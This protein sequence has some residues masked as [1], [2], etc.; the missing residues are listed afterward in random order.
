MKN[1]IAI[2]LYVLLFVTTLPFLD[3]EQD[4]EITHWF[5]QRDQKIQEWKRIQKLFSFQEAIVLFQ[6]SSLNSHQDLLEQTDLIKEICDQDFV[7]SCFSLLQAYQLNSGE[8]DLREIL[9]EDFLEIQSEIYK[10]PFYQ[11]LLLSQGQGH[12]LYLRLKDHLE[13]QEKLATF[14]HLLSFEKRGFSLASSV[15][16]NLAINERSELEGRLFFALFPL[17]FILFFYYF[18][19]SISLIFCLLLSVITSISI[20]LSIMSLCGV[21]QSILSLIIAPI[22]LILTL[23]SATHLLFQVERHLKSKGWKEAIELAKRDLFRTL[24][25]NKITSIAG[26]LTLMLSIILPVKATGLFSALG[27]VISFY[28]LMVFF[29]FLLLK[30]Q[31]K[32]LLLDGLTQ[33]LD[34]FNQW[35]NNFIRKNSHWI[36]RLT[37]LLCLICFYL[38]FHLT[39]QSKALYL[40]PQ[41][42]KI[43]RMHQTFITDSKQG[44][45]LLQ[46]VIKPKSYERVELQKMKKLMQKVL[47]LEEVH[48]LFGAL[49]L[50]EFLHD[51]LEGRRGFPKDL[52]FYDSLQEDSE[53][54]LESEMIASWIAKKELRTILS[55]DLI[56][57]KESQ[58]L[59][60]RIH[61]IFLQEGMQVSISGFYP[62]TTYLDL[63]LLNFLY[64]SL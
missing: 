31:P 62:L 14:D 59:T 45:N 54:D 13:K 11:K 3:L 50:I 26:F 58:K 5:S 51:N 28:S 19:R 37:L 22:L 34:P 53:N 41:D 16:L 52:S 8:E 18:S 24:F 47:D 35:C 61:Q 36:L 39:V 32:S 15:L 25:Y 42:H 27:L 57:P 9:E 56:N 48:S 4:N 60:Q 55:I 63:S 10:N 43:V 6:K 29:P 21:K 2:I 7:K 44:I 33:T 40:L 64:H 1:Y 30:I 49:D 38:I 20:T 23:S 12:F 46:V 17:A